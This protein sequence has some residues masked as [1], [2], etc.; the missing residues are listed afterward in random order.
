MASPDAIKCDRDAI[1]SE[2][3]HNFSKASKS[4]SKHEPVIALTRNRKQD[5]VREERRSFE[6]RSR[7]REKQCFQ[8]THSRHQ[9]SL[10]LSAEEHK[11]KKRSQQIKYQQSRVTLTLLRHNPQTIASTTTKSFFSYSHDS[12][13]QREYNKAQ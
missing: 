7:E 12:I 11:K 1:T 5:N 8:T 2:R 13:C 4:L 9:Q 10:P 6:E 3:V